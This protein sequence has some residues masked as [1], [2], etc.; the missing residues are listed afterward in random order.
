MGTCS[1]EATLMALRDAAFDKDESVRDQI[2]FSLQDLGRH[3]P[4]LVLMSCHNYLLKHSQLALGHRTVILQSME[5]I[6]KDNIRQVGQP[7]ARKLISMASDELTRSDEASSGYQDAAMNSLLV[8]LGSDFINQ[9]LEELTDKLQS[10][11]QPHFFVV[12]TLGDLALANPKGVI[13]HLR[14]ILQTLLP[15]LSMAKREQMKLA[16]TAALG[17]FSRSILQF[18]KESN[19]G[20][21]PGMR[22]DE[23][24]HEIYVAYD[25]L[26][27]NWLQCKDV[28]LRSMVL[29]TVGHMVHLLSDDRLNQELP[30]LIPGILALYKRHPEPLCVTQCLRHTLEAAMKIDTQALEVHVDTLLPALHQQICLEGGLVMVEFVVRQC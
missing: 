17:L 9:V 28:K 4:E 16:F 2:M 7:L 18:H 14:S 1:L 24:S 23:F 25:V 29:E 21:S 10:G 8:T 20:L 19:S 13:P 5:R 15:M 12:R 6:V 3:Y 22:K 11:V 26:F 30:K 27:N